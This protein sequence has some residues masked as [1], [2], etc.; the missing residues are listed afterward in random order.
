MKALDTNVLVRFLV[1]DDEHQSKIVYK[2][3]KQA[4]VDKFYYCV[5]L[6]VVL[7][8]IW[9]LESVYEIP[10]TKVLDSANELLLM[11]ILKF[12][13]QPTIQ[14]FIF[15]ARENKIEL[16]DVLIACAAKISGCERVLTFDKKASKFNL[17]ELIET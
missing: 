2:L 12:E 15:L 7:E 1:K 6:L 11:P 4:E 9:V 13:A 16:S 3:F 8:T 14:N 10:R 5:S 17:F